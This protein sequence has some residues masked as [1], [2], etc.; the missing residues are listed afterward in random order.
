MAK[1][2]NDEEKRKSKSFFYLIFPAFLI[3]V[4]S[5]ISTGSLS[6]GTTTILIIV[7]LLLLIWQYIV[8]KNFIEGVYI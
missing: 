7:K 8:I 2:F 5:F 4:I 3:T 6:F 1:K